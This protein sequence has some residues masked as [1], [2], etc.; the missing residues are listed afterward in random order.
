MTQGEPMAQGDAQQKPDGGLPAGRRSRYG[1]RW[2]RPPLRVLLWPLLAYLVL[3]LVVFIRQRSML[4]LPTPAV[5]IA[6]R[7]AGLPPGQVHPITVRADDQLEL[8]GWHVLPARQT[9]ANRQECDQ[10]LATA[11][12]LVLYFSGNGGN[13]RHRFAEFGI[14]ASLGA[15]VF[16]FDYRGYGDNE[17]SPSEKWL[18]ADAWS[19]WNYATVQRGVPPQRILLYG[20]SLGGAVAVR[21]AA[22]ACQAGSPPGGL[23]VRSTFS[24]LVDAGAY[25]YP[26]LPVRWGLIDRF[27]AVDHIPQVTC[28]LL[29]MHGSRDTIMP[30]TLGRRLF[31]AAPQRAAS[32]IAKQ[33]VELPGADHNDVTLVAR[34]EMR[35]AIGDFLDRLQQTSRPAG[36]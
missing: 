33:F 10:A 25:H 7:E 19:I 14:L 16:I 3:V 5:Q 20:E 21:L 26:W 27:A 1:A 30:I 15:H 28:P 31:A 32:G 11:R 13:R 22:R 6:P 4:Y 36:R 12:W 17:G 9:A 2:W 18:T 29:Q 24:S 8:R 35:R 23:I 34:A